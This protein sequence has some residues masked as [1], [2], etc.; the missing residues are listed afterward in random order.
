MAPDM[1]AA[2]PPAAAAARAPGIVVRR[3]RWR[4]AGLRVRPARIRVRTMLRSA[5]VRLAAVYAALFGVSAIA[6]MLF[7]WW[8]TAGLLE[9]QVEQAIRADAQ[10]LSEHWQEGGLPSLAITIQAR[11]DQ[12]VDDNSVYLLED[13]QGTRLAGNLEHWPREVTA[14]NIWYELPI[15]RAGMRG[16]AE[17]R[18]FSLP[19]GFRLLV[20]RDIRGRDMLRRLL[21][22]TL[23]YA[24]LMV[25]GLSVVGAVV[26]RNLFNRMVSNVSG[27]A[28]R[29]AAGD[30][31]QRVPLDGTGDEF[32]QVAATIND[33]LDRIARLMDGVRQ[34]SNAIAHDLRTPI[35]RARTELEGALAADRR[36][37][38]LRSA[39]ERAVDNL[40]GITR[41]FEALLRISEIE[42]GS[43]RAAF[44]TFDLVRLLDDLCEFYAVP[45][46]EKGIALSV[47]VPE[48]LGFC[49]DSA[50][51]QQAVANLL[52]NALKFSPANGRIGLEAGREGGLVTIVVSDQ[53]PGIPEADRM[54]AT[55]RFFRGEDARSTPGSGLGLALVQAVAHLHGGEVS[56]GDAGPGLIARLTLA[57]PDPTR[58]AGAAPA[59]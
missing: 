56:F 51:L 14:S 58:V 20:G 55:E 59:G 27:T 9:R 21:G 25:F 29:I 47:S 22:Q 8:D 34:V 7:L 24:L 50:L 36:E 57:A 26:V 2:L 42:A 12:D 48:A 31:A 54:R 4:R 49:G 44:A 16:L 43:R 3:P 40:D 30:L 32:D 39:I 38:E 18:A 53:G 17:M 52:D 33:M 23:L 37:P 11:L 28:T 10:A 41:V 13:A 1:Q 15:A 46:E 45:A 35:A 5:S 6:F 19:G